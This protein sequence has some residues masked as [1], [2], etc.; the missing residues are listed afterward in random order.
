[1]VNKFVW[2]AALLLPTLHAQF[3]QQGP[4]LVGTDTAGNAAEGKS[5]SISADGNTAIV[6]GYFDSSGRGA[7]WVY[8]RVGGVWMQQGPKLVGN[9]SSATAGQGISV[10]I[11][12]DGNTAIVGAP[13][14]GS[15]WVF[16][17]TSGVWTQ[18][19]PALFTPGITQG[20]RSVSISGDG[21]TA[22][23]AGP[24]AA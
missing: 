12:G 8:V 11:S 13:N 18:Q 5:V 3:L 23:V 24:G 4:K 21:N 20:G 16:A 17:R 15:A 10:A 1:M 22:L 19:G 9:G 2:A 7:A 6:G 14:V